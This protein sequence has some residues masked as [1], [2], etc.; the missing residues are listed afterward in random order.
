MLPMSLRAYDHA[1]LMP[2]MRSKV[3]PYS[4]LDL[5]PIVIGGSPADSF[6]NTL[7]L[8]RHAEQWGYRR[9]WL[10][11]HHNIPGVASAATSVIIGH[12]AGGTSHIRVGSGG[13]MLPNHAPLV[14]AE[15]FGTLESLYPGRIDL[16]I[17]RAPGGDTRSARAL[18]RNLGGSDRFPQD[19]QELRDYFRPGG[20]ENGVHAI[21][22]EGLNAPVWLRGSSDFSARLAADLGLPFAF[23]SH[24]PPDH[25]HEALA[26]Y[27]R[28]F[29]PS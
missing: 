23:A 8:A 25:L 18:R 28:Y 26:L 4:L 21:P 14:I 19:L 15:Q 24:F 5:S 7:D 20:P 1:A 22:G 29:E 12:V 13:I 3:I 6:K 17:G 27:R 16:G 9:Y 10:A 11:E 2:N